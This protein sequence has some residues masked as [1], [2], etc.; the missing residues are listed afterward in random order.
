MSAPDGE[1]GFTVLEALV[2]LVILTGTT[3]AVLGIIAANRSAQAKAGAKLA[4]ALAAQSLLE[5]VGL[6]IPLRLGAAGGIL[7][8]GRAYS[9]EVTAFT[10]DHEPPAP[11]A[12]PLFDVRVRVASTSAGDSAFELRTLKRGMP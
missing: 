6:D 2:A 5:R 8:D 4:N 10:D 3:A 9:I 7:D 11:R 1:R 12:R